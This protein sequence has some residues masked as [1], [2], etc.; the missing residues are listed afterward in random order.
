MCT[1][2]VNYVFIQQY[3][4]EVQQIRG[5]VDL[6]I[7]QCSLATSCTSASTVKA[8]FDAWNCSSISGAILSYQVR[9]IYILAYY[10]VPII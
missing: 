2:I 8:Y 1:Y 10:Y 7:M 4:D 9:V 3:R 6:A 5:S